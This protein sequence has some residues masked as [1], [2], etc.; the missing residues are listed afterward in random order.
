MRSG[1]S[2]HRAVAQ[3]N[4]LVTEAMSKRSLAKTMVS[5]M[6]ALGHGRFALAGYSMGGRFVLL[7]FLIGLEFSPRVVREQGRRID[8]ETAV[9]HVD[10]VRVQFHRPDTAAAARS[11]LARNEGSAPALR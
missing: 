6:A 10:G 7:L 11:G 3:E 2:S 5:L 9:V 1:P 8:H 4:S